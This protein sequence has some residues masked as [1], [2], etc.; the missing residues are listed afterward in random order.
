VGLYRFRP[1]ASGRMG[2][3]WTL[4][5]VRNAALVEFGSMGHMVYARVAL[6]RMGVSGACGL[7]ATHLNENDIALGSTDRLLEAVRNVIQKDAPQAV[8][9]LP[10]SVPEIIGTDL[11]A[12]ARELGGLYPKVPVIAFG[13][14]G[15]HEDACHG[16]EEALAVLARELALAPEQERGYAAVQ[17]AEPGTFNI[18]GSCSDRFRFRAEAAELER[19]MWGAFGMKSQCVM[20]SGASAED[21]RTLGSASLNLAVRE[22][23][24]AA[25]GWLKE[26]HGTPYVLGCPYGIEGTTRW[27]VQVG[28]S[29]GRKPDA[30]FISRE[31]AE[32]RQASRQLV[33]AIRY[34]K[35]KAR[36]FLGGPAESVAGIGA[37]AR[38]ELDMTVEA[39]WRDSPYGNSSTVPFYTE[40]QWMEAAKAAEGAILMASGQ[41]LQWAGQPDTLQIANPDLAWRINP[42]AP[43]FAGYRGAMHL[44]ELWANE[45]NRDG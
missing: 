29:I 27:L 43:P 23:A 1:P 16:V 32:A 44:M 39:A 4:S 26:N 12:L 6:E 42:Y 38:E 14:G 31:S 41:T 2:I 25:A 11:G 37:F 28:E 9:L 5:T 20:T 33:P 34:R 10:S 3:L 18:I 40:R 8:F 45:I 19:L 36:L 17:R 24:L 22:E 15:F 30:G 7:Y 21:L 13:K 35:G